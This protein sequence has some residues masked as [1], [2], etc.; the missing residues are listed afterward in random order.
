MASTAHQR[1]Q[2][3]CPGSYR[4]NNEHIPCESEKLYRNPGSWGTHWD[5]CHRD[6]YKLKGPIDKYKYHCIADCN[7]LFEQPGPLKVHLFNTHAVVRDDNAPSPDVLAPAQTAVQGDQWQRSPCLPKTELPGN[8]QEG[9]ARGPADI[10]HAPLI[11]STPSAM[12]YQEGSFPQ[13]Y[14][15]HASD[16]EIADSLADYAFT[17]G[18][19]LSF[20]GSIP[21]S[22]GYI[23]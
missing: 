10:T 8:P 19:G 20:N 15:A 18:F 4:S 17:T 14:T 23:G 6:R 13:T 5:K 22:N 11:A 1:P 7:K 9:S 12:Y 21:Y 2:R 16:A 3:Q